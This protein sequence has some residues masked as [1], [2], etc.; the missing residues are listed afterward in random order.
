LICTP[1]C[2]EAHGIGKARALH[3]GLTQAF[4]LD[5]KEPAAGAAGAGGIESG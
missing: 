3:Y 2:Q 4:A 5:A 1:A